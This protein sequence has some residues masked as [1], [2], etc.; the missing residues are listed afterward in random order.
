MDIF[1]I[2]IFAL[3]LFY[4]R[5]GLVFTVMFL[6]LTICNMK[7]GLAGTQEIENFGFALSTRR[8]L[9][10]EFLYLNVISITSAGLMTYRNTSYLYLMAIEDRF[11]AGF[12][13]LSIIVPFR[14]RFR[15]MEII[16]CKYGAGLP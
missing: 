5:Q 6:I 12:R 7:N 4:L 13:I 16:A 11:N 9:S 8:T 14:S 15:T 2:T 1:K 3:P 10:L